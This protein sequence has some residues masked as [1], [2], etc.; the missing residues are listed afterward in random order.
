MD[1]SLAIISYVY[2]HVKQRRWGRERKKKHVGLSLSLV[3]FFCVCLVVC[4][5]SLQRTK[6]PRQSCGYVKRRGLFFSLLILLSS[7]IHRVYTV[8]IYT[9]MQ[10]YINLCSRPPQPG[11]KS[12]HRERKRE[13][14]GS[15][16]QISQMPIREMP[17]CALLSCSSCRDEFFFSLS[18]SPSLYFFS[19]T[20]RLWVENK[21]NRNN[22]LNVYR[23]RDDIERRLHGSLPDWSNRV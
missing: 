23:S 15:L 3:R 21:K 7:Y 5:C 14:D 4:V 19:V 6:H 20:R 9:F 18:C 22:I 8:Y 13:K 16:Q 10:A 2:T 12:S 11:G 17:I 1:P